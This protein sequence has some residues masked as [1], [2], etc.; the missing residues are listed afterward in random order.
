MLFIFYVSSS[1]KKIHKLSMHSSF[2]LKVFNAQ[3]AYKFN[4]SKKNLHYI[5]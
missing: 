5:A 4:N 2:Y 3:S 1:R